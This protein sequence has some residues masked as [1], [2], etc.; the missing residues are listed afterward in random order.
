M[1]TWTIERIARIARRAGAALGKPIVVRHPKEVA[2]LDA[3]MQ[4]EQESRLAFREERA[5]K[6][7][8]ALEQLGLRNGYATGRIERRPDGSYLLHKG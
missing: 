4:W 8:D 2:A 7:A 6:V 5:K 1:L 3:L